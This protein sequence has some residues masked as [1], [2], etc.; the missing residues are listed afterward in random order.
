MKA[1]KKLTWIELK[2]FT[3]DPLSLVFTLALPLFFLIVLNGVF[4]NEP[5]VDPVEDVWR[6]VG[7]ADYYV[8]AYL[9]LVMAAIGVL[10]MPVRLASY[11]ES[12]VL[13][14]FRAS[15]MPLWSI[16]GSQIL[17]AMLTAVFGA[18]SITIASTLIYGTELPSEPFLLIPAFFLAALSFSALGVF[19]GSVLPTS[20]SAQSA[21]IMLFFVM[22]LLSGSGP[23]PDA[24]TGAMRGVSR[25]L[26]LTHVVLLLQDPWLG[27]GWHVSA[28]IVVL[29]V[30]V[31]S[32]LLSIR[33]FRWE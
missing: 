7:P 14:R 28:S 4:G 11:R 17:I 5:E 6:G 26:P 31:A 25:A 24:L 9:G 23:P 1:L 29:A 16:L 3:R 8:P 15:A 10:S 27:F 2:L 12:G 21:G 18:I 30:L 22:F 20:R 13:R 19:L 32:V 33:F